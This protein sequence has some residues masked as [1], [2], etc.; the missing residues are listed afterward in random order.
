MRGQDLIFAGVNSPGEGT[1][2]YIARGAEGLLER[3]P[4]IE[5]GPAGTT[6]LDT[7]VVGDLL[8]VSAF[9][10][11]VGA[12]LFKIDLSSY[13]SVLFADGFESGDTT[14]W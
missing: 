6:V 9:R 14:L 13:P 5:P 7:E 1:E 4:S 3:L 10:K 11:D 2:L 8:Y 12:E